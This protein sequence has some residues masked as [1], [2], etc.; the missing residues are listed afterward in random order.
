MYHFCCEEED[1]EGREWISNRKAGFVEDG[2]GV[3]V[4]R[5]AFFM[6]MEPLEVIVS[7][8]WCR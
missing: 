6:E 8:S 4:L 7:S 5:R 2:T 3:E 1:E